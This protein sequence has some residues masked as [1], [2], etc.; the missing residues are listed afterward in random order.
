MFIHC[1]SVVP[2]LR[3]AHLGSGQLPEAVPVAGRRHAIRDLQHDAKTG[4]LNFFA[5]C[6]FSSYIQSFTK[7]LVLGCEN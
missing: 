1:Q 5:L 6:M 2:S 3:R 7:R 4:K